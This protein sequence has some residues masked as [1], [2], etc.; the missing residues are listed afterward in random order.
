MS[1]TLR[2]GKVVDTVVD[3]S[4]VVASVKMDD[5]LDKLACSLRAEI[6][7]VIDE[8]KISFNNELS[9]RD[10]RILA[11]E[12]ELTAQKSQPPKESIDLVVA[13]DSIVKHFNVDNFSANNKVICLPGA[14][15]HRVHREITKLSTT[16]HIKD[17]VVHFGTNS[18]PLDI[19]QARRQCHP[20]EIAS[21]VKD[22]LKQIQLQNLST[23]LHF[24]AIL[25]KV[26]N[27]YNKGI[28][29][30][31]ENIHD[32][33]TK[34]DIGFIKHSDFSTKGNFKKEFF[35]PREWRDRRVVHP[36]SEGATY[37]ST[38]I[39]SHLTK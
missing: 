11:L 19:N 2:S 23:R 38:N 14:Q 39:M 37:M 15:C 26:N 18:I 3:D 4:V 31:N 17:L 24:S 29:F 5:M 20:H 21:E 9:L 30:I 25:P 8:L 7:K 6:S 35:A 1:K 34:N 12:N 36:S 16:A 13:G 33:C 32:F 27:M 10:A 22:T 28:N